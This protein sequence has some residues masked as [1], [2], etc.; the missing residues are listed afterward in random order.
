MSSPHTDPLHGHCSCRSEHPTEV[1]IHHRRQVVRCDCMGRSLAPEQI[2]VPPFG[3]DGLQAVFGPK[4]L[5]EHLTSLVA[6]SGFG[7][8]CP[9]TPCPFVQM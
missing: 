9:V 3:G 8:F 1:T 6:P 4:P 5:N 2:A 7:P